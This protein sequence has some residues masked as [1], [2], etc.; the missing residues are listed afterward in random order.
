[1]R[2]I[3]NI[4]RLGQGN[5]LT[6]DKTKKHMS[7]FIRILEY[8]LY[9][10]PCNPFYNIHDIEEALKRD[11]LYNLLNIFFQV[12]TGVGFFGLDNLLRWA[13]SHDFAAL[14]PSLWP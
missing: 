11:V 2:N 7:F 9:P 10:L 14:L 3:S 4:R 1:M 8:I 6:R 5:F 12:T 13:L